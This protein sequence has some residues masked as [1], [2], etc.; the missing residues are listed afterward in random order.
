MATKECSVVYNSKAAAYAA[1]FEFLFH[2]FRFR[3]NDRTILGDRDRVF[4]VGGD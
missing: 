4:K 3:E 1:A 2:L